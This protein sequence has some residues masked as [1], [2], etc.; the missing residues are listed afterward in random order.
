MLLPCQIGLFVGVNNFKKLL[1]PVAAIPL[2]IFTSL[3][4]SSLLYLVLFILMACVISNVEL[5]NDTNAAVKLAFPNQWFLIPGVL[6]VGIGAALQ[7]LLLSA[8][9]LRALT[10]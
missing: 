10:S 9:V 5:I 4:I 2:G 1:N 6:M 7:C 3:T 8:N